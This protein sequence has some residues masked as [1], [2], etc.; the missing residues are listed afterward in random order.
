MLIEW[1][2]TT[3]RTYTVVYSDN[4]LFLNAMIAPPAV[5]A[6]ANRT[7]WIDYGPPT[8]TNVP[9]NTGARFYRVYQNP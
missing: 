8:T 4:V 9:A 3:N 7:Q 6:P 2:S 5:V 1:P